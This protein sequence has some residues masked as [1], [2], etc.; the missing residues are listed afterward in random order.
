[1]SNELLVALFGL[2]FLTSL[3]IALFLRRFPRSARGAALFASAATALCATALL[4]LAGEDPHLVLEWLPGTGP[5]AFGL[6][7]TGLYAALVT[8][9]AAF[10]ALL[11]TTSSDTEVPPLSL[12]LM[13]S[14]LAAASVAFLTKHFL[15]RYVALEI[16]ALSIALAPLVELRGD[17]GG[18]GF[19]LIYVVLRLGD[20]GL[21]SAILILFDASGTLEITPALQAADTLAAPGIGWVVFGL[22]LAVWV[23]LGNWPLHLWIGWGRSLAAN[24]QAW[25][26][27]T[28]MPNLG[29]YLLYRITS[30]L[31]PN[32]AVQ[33]LIL[34]LGAGAAMLAV[35]T[36]LTRRDLR[37]ALIYIAAA[38]GGLLVFAAA[39][40]MKVVVWLGLL[41]TTPL[42]IL[43]FLTGEA[44][45]RGETSLPGR[46]MQALFALAGLALAAFGLLITW[47]ARQRGAP[48]DALFVAEAAVALL[49]VWAVREASRSPET[50]E[51]ASSS[52]GR[53]AAA[54]TL[55][56]ATLIGASTAGL[57]SRRLVDI[58][59]YAPPPIPTLSTLVRYLVFTPAL[60]LIM[61][62]VL[63][64][65]RMQKR[66]RIK[67]QM[68][69]PAAGEQIEA[70][71]D[72][73]EGLAH[74]AQALRA[75]VEVGFLEQLIVLSVR[76]VVDGSRIIYRFVEQEG[77]EGI[78]KRT[79]QG[80]L[81]LSRETRRYHTGLLR[82]NLMWIPL[83][84]MLALVVTL[85]C[86]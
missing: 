41:A 70:T 86:W 50:T 48:L 66:S 10:L 61:T 55:G 3:V 38:R 52:I 7:A 59:G 8:T 22:L 64:L 75:V 6:G 73:Q 49:T 68:P 15:A 23:K 4:P 60:L 62:L 71:Y 56:L 11:G 85:T 53:W 24:T 19:W 54:G 72:L 51:G 63:F 58:A 39:S 21:L 65:W 76:A 80:V 37:S 47:W 1:M 46:A 36:A 78:I 27:T 82:H 42:Q 5:M 30:L 29:V 12:A 34:W 13:L 9:W 33:T 45:E 57:L 2:P 18:R 83:S 28:V 32:A 81:A 40:G 17:R 26:F 31:T 25:L 67:L 69:G 20:V 74:A 43:L 84:L 79:T 16:V 14:A 44:P 35:L 77:L